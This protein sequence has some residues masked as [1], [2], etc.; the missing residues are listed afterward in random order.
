M[1]GEN[2]I[3]LVLAGGGAK[4]AFQIGVLQAI[5]EE[6]LLPYV[7]AVSGTSA[8]ALNAA[9][10]LNSNTDIDKMAE[11]W[12]DFT[13]SDFWGM[14]KLKKSGHSSWQLKKLLKK[15][16]IIPPWCNDL[17]E[18]SGSAVK[19][20]YSANGLE[21]MK[22]DNE[23]SRKL[24]NYLMSLSGFIFGGI[25]SQN[26]ISKLIY[27]NIHIYN[28]FASY[29]D[30]YITCFQDFNKDGNASETFLINGKNGDIFHNNKKWTPCHI[31]NI[32]L[33]SIALPIYAP[34]D[35]NG[36]LYSDGGFE[37]AL[38]PQLATNGIANIPYNVLLE[39]D[40]YQNLIIIDFDK[41]TIA[42]KPNKKIIEIKPHRSDLSDFERFI[43]IA[44]FTKEN[45][46]DLILEGKKEAKKTFRLF[47]DTVEKIKSNPPPFKNYKYVQWNTTSVYN[48][49]S[50]LASAINRN[51]PEIRFKNQS[52][53]INNALLWIFSYNNKSPTLIT[54]LVDLLPSLKIYQLFLRNPSIG[55]SAFSALLRPQFLFIPNIGFV[56]SGFLFVLCFL[57]NIF[58]KKAIDQ[59]RKYDSY[60]IQGSSEVVLYLN[61]I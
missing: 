55:F 11:I 58:G 39:N 56:S 53:A 13:A 27:E 51:Q 17:N 61:R 41:N 49:L 33:A 54:T 42:P 46:A 44:D 35:V 15:N 2:E 8:G 4:G 29:I 3:G 21:A 22:S 45:I 50:E 32:L 31:H 1:R 18:E 37:S 24:K 19:L 57:Y 60:P 38:S 5:K 40:S 52:K 25:A 34:V 10:L 9:L 59:I 30:C 36:K 6:G 12:L 26:V 20:L 48:Q 23:K 14:R 43:G 7:T 47:S 16:I 28:T